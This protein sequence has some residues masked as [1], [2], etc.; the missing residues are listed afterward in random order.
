MKFLAILFFI[1]SLGAVAKL[2]IGFNQAWLKNNYAHQ[3]IHYDE[4]EAQ[5]IIKLT[6]NAHAKSLRIW[7][8]EGTNSKGINWKN[9]RPLSIQQV[10]LNNLENFIQ[11][12]SIH[13]LKLNITFFD[14]NIIHQKS[15]P[16]YKERWIN[17]FNSKSFSNEFLFNIIHPV[18]LIFNRYPN[19]VTQIDI[20]NEINALNTPYSNT[21][22]LFKESWKGLNNFLCHWREFIQ[23]KSSYKIKVSSSFGWAL[24]TDELLKERLDSR[25]IDY[26]D[27]HLYNDQGSIRRCSELMSLSDKHNIPIQIGEFGQLSKEFSDDV[28]ASVL[29]SFYKNAK[30]CGINNL[31]AWRLSDIRKNSSPEERHSFETKTRL[32]KA[33]YKLKSINQFEK[34]EA[35]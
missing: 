4:V 3:W 29:N 30:S 21:P 12:A 19:T 33:Y 23:D 20:V 27:I 26:Y 10:F 34:Q 18:L 22:K 5:R 17:L 9:E 11:Q 7:L 8:F 15:F 13:K 6:K 24:A 28:Q 35:P 32:R 2:N 14:A 31:L 16:L 1:Y 25:C